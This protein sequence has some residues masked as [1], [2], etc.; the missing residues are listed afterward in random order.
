MSARDLE[1]TAQHR[2]REC[3]NSNMISIIFHI[4]KIFKSFCRNKWGGEVLSFYLN[5]YENIS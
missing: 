5:S 2:I 4:N 1:M 3:G